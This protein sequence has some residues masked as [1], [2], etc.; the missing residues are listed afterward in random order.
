MQTTLVGTR[1]LGKPASTEALAGRTETSYSEKLIVCLVTVLG[2][3]HGTSGTVH[4]AGLR[5]DVG[6]DRRGVLSRSQ[7]H[8]DHVVQGYGLDVVCVDVQCRHSVRWRNRPLRNIKSKDF[9][10]NMRIGATLRM[11]P[12]GPFKQHPVL[13][14]LPRSTMPDERKLQRT[15][16]HTLSSS[17]IAEA[18]GTARQT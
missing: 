17:K 12:D 14:S 1:L 18:A 10:T 15:E 11:F 5:R 3:P 4:V 6:C 8:V 16:L 7:L 2:F 13:D 9:L